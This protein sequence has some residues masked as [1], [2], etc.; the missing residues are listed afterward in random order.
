ME[1]FYDDIN[2]FQNKRLAFETDRL[3]FETYRAAILGDELTYW[4]DRYGT[5]S[6]DLQNNFN[7]DDFNHIQPWAVRIQPELFLMLE[8][9]EKKAS[10]MANY[11][12]TIENRVNE[13]IEGERLPGLQNELQN[14]PPSLSHLQKLTL[15]LLKTTIGLLEKTINDRNGN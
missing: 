11:F 3:A 7:P 14:G 4:Q 6:S 8:L 10:I 2:N 12:S 15:N 9:Q 1:G 5:V 13:K